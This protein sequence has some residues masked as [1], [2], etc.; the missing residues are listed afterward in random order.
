MHK[1][2]QIT[3]DDVKKIAKLAD[4]PLRD[5]EMEKF[6][7]QFSK[8]V[9]VVNELNELDTKGLP[10]TY[11]V[12]NLKNIMRQDKV[13]TSRTLSQDDALSQ[14]SKTHKGYFV[15]PRVIDTDE[16]ETVI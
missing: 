10:E 8:T 12:N 6:A 11:Q 16:T 4:L 14:A 5:N 1:A 13:D 15:V 7:G 2:V 3:T 9:E